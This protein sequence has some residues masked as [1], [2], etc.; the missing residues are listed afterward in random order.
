MLP[1]LLCFLLFA[2]LA[3]Y[4]T[5]HTYPYRFFVI[6]SILRLYRPNAPLYRSLPMTT[7]FAPVCLRSAQHSSLVLHKAFIQQMGNHHDNHQVDRKERLRHHTT[8]ELRGHRLFV[9][10]WQLH[11]SLDSPQRIHVAKKTQN[12]KSP[13]PIVKHPASAT[14]VAPESNPIETPGIPRPGAAVQGDHAR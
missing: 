10:P 4:C 5:S 12:L 13:R 3:W 1:C 8:P 9:E 6:V 2:L 7:C 14:V 11:P